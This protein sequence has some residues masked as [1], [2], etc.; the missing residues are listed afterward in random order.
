MSAATAM[1][2]IR[3]SNNLASSVATT[4]IANISVSPPAA[5]DGDG[6]GGASRCS[7]AH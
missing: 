6:V 4:T 7:R 3:A 2:A 1:S 5:G